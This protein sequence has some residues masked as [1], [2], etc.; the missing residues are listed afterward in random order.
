MATFE[1]DLG[2]LWDGPFLVLRKRIKVF[3][4]VRLKIPFLSLK[5][6]TVCVGKPEQCH[7]AVKKKLVQWLSTK[8]KS[9]GISAA[10]VTAEL[11]L[12]LGSMILKYRALHSKVIESDL[13]LGERAKKPPKPLPDGFLMVH[14]KKDSGLQSNWGVPTLQNYC[15]SHWCLSKMAK[16]K[17][18]M[19]N[20]LPANSLWQLLKPVMMDM[21][22]SYPCTEP[23]WGAVLGSEGLRPVTALR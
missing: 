16:D 1:K 6:E 13:P 8:I 12:L 21:Y 2:W 15:Q 9:L 18:D 19:E 5:E 3:A 4:M 23:L 10:W 11:Q 7:F 22:L 14:V 17:R 20:L